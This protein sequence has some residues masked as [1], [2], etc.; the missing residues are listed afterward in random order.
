VFEQVIESIAAKNTPQKLCPT[1]SS[2]AEKFSAVWIADASTLEAMKK[3][4]GQLQQKAG[5]VLA[6]KLI[7]FPPRS[8]TSPTVTTDSLACRAS[9]LNGLGQSSSSVSLTNCCY[10]T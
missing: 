2:V 6:G 7:F 5:S 9:S 10:V 4:F 8:F 1:W 3:H